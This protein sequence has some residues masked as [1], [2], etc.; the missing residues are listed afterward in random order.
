MI[1]ERHQLN[2]TKINNIE[3]EERDHQNDEGKTNHN[4]SRNIYVKRI[5]KRF[6]TDNDGDNTNKRKK[7]N[8][9]DGNKIN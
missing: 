9:N 1:L 5:T 4:Y 8:F 2:D 6:K 7:V 3:L